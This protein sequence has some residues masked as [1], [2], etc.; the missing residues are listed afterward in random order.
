MVHANAYIAFIG[1]TPMVHVNACTAFLLGQGPMVRT[2]IFCLSLVYLVH[3]VWY[4]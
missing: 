1:F 4:T 3:L 2:G